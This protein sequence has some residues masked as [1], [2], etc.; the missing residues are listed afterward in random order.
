M[1]MTSSRKSIVV[2]GGGLAGNMTAI[3]LANSLGEDYRI[4]QIREPAA[5]REDVLYGGVT[6]PGGY[7]FLRNLGLDE[8]ALLLK[9]ATSFSY[10]THFRRWLSSQSWMQCH[11]SPFPTL[12]GI[13]LRHLLSRAKI[14]LEPLLVSAQAALAGRFAHPPADPNVVLSRAEYGY[15]FDVT[16]WTALLDRRVSECRTQGINASI[17]SVEVE[18]GRLTAIQLDTGETV[19]ADLFIDASGPS[20]H[21]ALAAG[22]LFQSCRT[23]SVRSAIKA[24]DQVGPPCRAIEADQL[25]WTATTFLQNAEHTLHVGAADGN[26]HAPPDFSIELGGLTDAW[27]SNCVAIGHAASVFEPLTPAPMMMLQRDIE[28][29][30]EL[31]PVRPDMTMERR[32]FNRRYRQD[33]AHTTVFHNAILR[34][35]YSP[36]SSYWRE[37]SSE[38]QSEKLERKIA[39]FTNRGV[40]TSYDLEPFNDEDWTIAHLGMGRAPRQ[41]DRQVNRVPEEQAEHYLTQIKCSIQQLVPKMPPHHIYVAKLKQYL[42][43]QNHV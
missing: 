40:L 24:A 42:E 9:S 18:D 7:N 30:L 34:S 10:G 39:Q 31:I 19:V 35:D 8:P 43:K 12:S 25:G 3:S 38:A 21:C 23:I 4:I 41:Y 5:S 37:V 15:Q 14:P 13:P 36:T 2:C 28:R 22:G 16:E 20:R 1:P 29:L 27:V 32:E 11:H 17:K 33:M 26:G 6:D